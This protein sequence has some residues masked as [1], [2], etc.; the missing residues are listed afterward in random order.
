MQ[1]LL[2]NQTQILKTYDYYSRN[3]IIEA[4]GSVDIETFIIDKNDKKI[5][6]L[7]KNLMLLIDN[8]GLK[9][10]ATF[11]NIE[12]FKKLESVLINYKVYININ[13][14]YLS[15]ITDNE[16][17]DSKLTKYKRNELLIFIINSFSLDLS[18]EKIEGP[19]KKDFIRLSININDMKIYNQ[20]SINGKFSCF[21]KNTTSPFITFCNEIN[22]YNEL[23]IA[24]IDYQAF[25]VG[26]ME[27]GIDPA[28]INDIFSFLDN[29]L[30]RMNIT[31]FNI[32]KLFLLISEEDE[33][34]NI[35]NEYNK[36][37]ILI[38]A[39]N[40][41][42]PLFYIK[43]E[44]SDVGVDQFLKETMG[45][46]EFYIW[47]IKGLIGNRHKLTLDKEKLTYKNGGIIQYLKWFYDHYEEKIESK[48][49]TM[50][51]TGIIGHFKNIL[52]DVDQNKTKV[53][54][55]RVRVPRVFYGKFQYMKKYNEKEELLIKNTFILNY[56]V[57]KDKY[58][59]NSIIIGKNEF[60]LFT[61]IALLNVKISNYE[62]KKN[63]KYYFIKNI[64]PS[65]NKIKVNY[66]QMIDSRQFYVIICDDEEKQKTLVNF[67][68]KK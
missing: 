9:M 42:F 31:N 7:N 8:N 22:Y 53:Q 16:Y 63:I 59:P 57:L 12:D 47:V 39:T 26:K 45:C 18:R 13:K 52:A 3:F 25:E 68:M 20:K 41:D 1:I 48:I 34:K 24:K 35:I 64:E 4:E 11:Y 55:N 49:T 43:F 21:F 19:L 6:N 40:L 17:S 32:H 46:S 23:R 44:L 15:I 37:N 62:I 38:N 50:G 27:V 10:K 66:T 54:E 61:N 58:Y 67:L 33:Q 2:P 14:I 60:F 29:I 28:F 5:R 65:R 51:I 30:Y 56:K 36:A